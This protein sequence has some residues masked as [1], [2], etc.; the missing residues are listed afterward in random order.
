LPRALITGITGQD[1]ILLAHNLLDRGYDVIGFARRAS[2]VA[3]PELHDLFAR[4]R[5][6][7]GDAADSA[8]L[9]DAIAH[10]QPDEL[11]NLAAQS[12]PGASWSQSLETGE[13]TAMG[14]HRLF[15][16]VH[17]FAPGCRVYHASSSEMFGAVLES[18]QRES[19]PFNPA[20]PYAVAK[21]YAHHMAHVYRRAYGLFIACGILFNHESPYRRMNF[22]TQK[23]AYGAACASLGIRTST[24]L[25]EE[26]EPIVQNGRLRLGNLDAS[27]DWGDARD[28]VEAMRLMLQQPAADDFVIGTGQLRTVRDLCASAYAHVNLDW[29]DFVQTDPRFL[30]PSETGATVA[31]ASK[32]RTALGWQPVHRFEDTIALMV[33]VHLARLRQA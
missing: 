15:D 2:V 4:I 21:V 27:R 17:R 28:Y 10:Q 19:T 12:A 18:P 33:D 3:R 6:V 22:L 25:N 16:A 32:A 29:A 8:D 7:H 24:A 30:R 5:L 31:D 11:Y 20:N 23:V 9:V 26:G 14:A 13:V 1:G